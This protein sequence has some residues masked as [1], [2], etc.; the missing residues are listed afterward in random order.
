MADRLRAALL[1]T[2]GAVLGFG[3]AVGTA[4]LAGLGDRPDGRDESERRLLGEV[5]DRIRR[6]YVEPVSTRQL[7]ESAA[8]GMVTGLDS[9]SR[10]LDAD[11]Y[12]DIRISTSGNYSGVGLEVEA[13]GE[14]L[15]VTPIEGSPAARAGVQAGDAL[16]RVDTLTVAGSRV[17]DVIQ[18]LRGR[19]GT[20]VDIA[21]RR[22]GAPQLLSFHLLRGPVQVHSVRGQLLDGGIGYLRISH[23]TDRTAA[24]LD[25]AIAELRRRQWP[26]SGVVLDLRNNPGGVLEAA[27]AVTDAFL[28][29]GIIVSASGRSRNA[30]FRHDAETGDL[31]EGAPLAVLVNG[32]SASAAE[33]VAG[34]LQDHGRATL[35]GARTFGKGSV[36]T[37]LPLSDGRGIKL[38][39][40][41][42]FTPSGASIHER[43][44]AP[45]VELPVGVLAVPADATRDPQVLAA[46]SALTGANP[47]APWLLTRAGR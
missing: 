38:T 24:D 42:Y 26:L 34:A 7:V 4:V 13:S 39:T 46:V 8:R 22:A 10:F 30:S 32:Q 18:R 5:I 45:D 20:F 15:L 27:V 21:A 3:L 9:H 19:P 40:S 33:I 31:T 25:A 11:E 37:V 2:S 12:E 17:T 28:D 41:R 29:A 36:Q 44:I 16:V 47:G 1:L 43:G 14:Q 23:F 6:E 35:L